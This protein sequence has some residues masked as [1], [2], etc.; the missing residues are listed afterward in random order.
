MSAEALKLKVLLATAG[1]WHLPQSA[2]AFA[3]RHA[4]AGLWISNKNSTRVP[5][6]LYR[7]CWPFHV[8]MKPFYHC[9]PQIV[10]EHA[11]Y[12]FF[13]IWKAWLKSQSW[14]EANVVQTIAG[15]GTELFDVAKKTGALKVVDCPNS[16]PLSYFGFWQR[17]CDLWCPGEN[18]PIPRWMF[19]RMNRELE[20]ADMIIVQSS[21]CR[22][23]MLWNGIPA[24]KIVVNPMGVDTSIFF[25]REKV[26]E[27]PRFI[28][29][30]TI[31]LRKGH[32]YLFRA[33]EQVKKKLPEAEL[34]CVGDYKTDFRRER[35]KWEGT[36]TH[37]RH[38]SH[39][40]LA[41]L[42]QTCTA[43]VFPSQEEGIARA[44]IEALAAGLPVI[45]THEGGAT[46]LV[47]DG[48]EGFIVRGRDPQH[49]AE[50]ML[51][52]ARDPLLCQRMGEAA[53]KKG[54]VKNTWQD[55]GD[56]LL[57]EYQKRLKF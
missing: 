28:S 45:G 36:F 8:A 55:Y 17:E 10:E 39:P 27:K 12:A 34:I 24:G 7:R 6:E 30:G 18:V 42:L 15:Y 37:Y 33:F 25:P 22:D 52:I 38:L 40:E 46:T 5:A 51:R 16:H 41:K 11:F 23:S 47:Q 49:I 13:P 1:S 43:F 20:Q 56:R 31:C 50:A 9:A 44:Q 54:A 3:N 35:P 19:A 29:V 21:F 4:L 57:A 48:V 53:H 32:Q 14:P 26:P 2:R